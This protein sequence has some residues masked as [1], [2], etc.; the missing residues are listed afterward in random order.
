MPSLFFS[1]RIM[2]IE[3]LPGMV[4]SRILSFLALENK[5]FNGKELSKLARSLLSES[6][7]LDFWVKRAARNLLDALSESSVYEWISGFSLDSG[8]ESVGEEFESLPD[9]LKDMAATHDPI[10]SWLPL[11]EADFVPRFCDDSLDNDEGLFSQVEEIGENYSR[12]VGKEIEMDQVLNAPLE[13]EIEKMAVSLR[14][15]VMNFES[16]LKAVALANEIRQLCLDIGRNSFQ[17]L[18]LVEP[19]KAE[20]ET[21]SVL[22]SHLSSGDEEELAWP[23]QVLCSTLLPK[24]LVLQ[25]PASRLLV[26]STID[27]CKIHQRAAVQA[28]L[29]PL[30]LRRE[31]INNPICDVITR[32]VRECLH[33]AHVSAFFQKL[34]CG[35]EEERKFILLPCHQCL[36]SDELVWTDS[37]FN[38]FQN[39]LNLNVH[40]TQD[41][42]DCLVYH[43]RQMAERFS[44]SLKFGN[45]MLCLVS[46]CAS[47]LKSH[48]EVLTEAVECTNT[49]VTKSILLRL[50]SF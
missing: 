21:A 23:S 35:G 36:V 17:V 48:K 41:S 32:I 39:I 11:S 15:R 30:V 46:K 27:Y 47:L 40:L 9:W 4:Q 12:D 37:L 14:A 24:F 44:K 26:T 20:D 8:E 7:E 45:F 6:R 50:A 18:S 49:I 31:G 2:F 29:F 22:I 19:W 3:T 34:L 33:P 28:L 25:E 1:L 43:V 42:V 16:S 38:L 13:P 5:R 10:L